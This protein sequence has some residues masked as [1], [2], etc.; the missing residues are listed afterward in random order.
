MED[1]AASVS[2]LSSGTAAATFAL[3][4]TASNRSAPIGFGLLVAQDPSTP[5]NVA[6][7]PNS[8]NS[9]V[10]GVTLSTYAIEKDSI[11]P[12]AKTAY[13][14]SETM[15]VVADTLSNEGINCRA[16]EPDISRTDVVYSSFAAA[17]AGYATKSPVN[18]TRAYGAKFRASSFTTSAGENVVLVSVADN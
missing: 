6:H 4:T 11:G 10:V 17:T 16:I 3:A 15:D 8:T 1:W 12:D 7:L 14:T 18:A 2:V 9:K 5:D 13:H